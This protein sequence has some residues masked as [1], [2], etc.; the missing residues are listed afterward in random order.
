[1]QKNHIL[2]RND[3]KHWG[4]F[5]VVVFCFQTGCVIGNVLIKILYLVRD[6]LIENYVKDII[7]RKP[8]I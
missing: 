8:Q 1:M 7:K 6:V 5:F 3:R 4:Y 2:M